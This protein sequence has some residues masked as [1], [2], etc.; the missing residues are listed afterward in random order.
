MLRL[1]EPERAVLNPKRPFCRFELLYHSCSGIRLTV[2]DIILYFVFGYLVIQF[3]KPVHFA[4]G[5]AVMASLLGLAFGDSLISVLFSGAVLFAY[6]AF[7]YMVVDRYVGKVLAPFGI[8][9]VGALVMF[10]A[11][12]VA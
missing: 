2:F 7:V 9:I 4:G 1:T 3:E 8:L 12:F 5:F 10:G 11:A 6:S